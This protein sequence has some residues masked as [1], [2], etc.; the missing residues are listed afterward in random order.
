MRLN[1]R[2]AILSRRYFEVARS[3]IDGFVVTGAINLYRYASMHFYSRFNPKEFPRMPVYNL[4]FL[5][6]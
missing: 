4:N 3:D 6:K 5:Y 2:I 1:F